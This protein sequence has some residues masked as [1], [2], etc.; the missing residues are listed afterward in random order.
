MQ[1][2]ASGLAGPGSLLVDHIDHRRIVAQ[3]AVAREVRESFLQG[4]IG[5]GTKQ[6]RGRDRSLLQRGHLERRGADPDEAE[7]VLLEAGPLQ[8]LRGQPDLADA[9]RGHADDLALEVHE[10]LDP[11][12]AGQHPIGPVHGR[13]DGGEVRAPLDRRDRGLGLRAG[14]LIGAG[15]QAHLD[16]LVAHADRK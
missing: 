10:A 13:R 9:Q 7:L 8:Q 11:G 5:G 2:G 15:D 12:R 1:G 4:E 16:L 3:V 14:D 6:H